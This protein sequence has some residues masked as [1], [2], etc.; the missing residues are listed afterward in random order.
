[1][2]NL[3]FE[4]IAPFIYWLSA[5]LFLLICL[6]RIEST[7]KP[8]VVNVV[9]GLAVNA[10]SNAMTYGLMI[11]YGLSASLSS[12][13]DQATI[14]HW[15]IVAALAKVVGPFVTAMLAFAAKNNIGGPAAVTLPPLSAPPAPAAAAPAAP[16]TP[17]PAAG[18]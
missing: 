8:I 10:G 13:A 7:V 5:V 17:A 11:G 3:S 15:V 14:L 18:A 2:N 6:W 9:N 16:V 4:D 12:L 1:M